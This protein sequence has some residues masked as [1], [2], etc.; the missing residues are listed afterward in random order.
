MPCYVEQRFILIQETDLC[1]GK[2]E[3][4][5]YLKACGMTLDGEALEQAYQIGQ[6][7][8]YAVRQVALLIQADPLAQSCEKLFGML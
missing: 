7:N 6:G 4:E 1:L 3:V 2:R 5:T 8:A